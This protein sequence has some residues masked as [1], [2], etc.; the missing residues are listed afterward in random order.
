MRLRPRSLA[1]AAVTLS[2]ALA[3]GACGSDDEPGKAA[4]STGTSASPSAGTSE[5]ASSA[6]ETDAASSSA[7][8][9][10][11]QA[12]PGRAA[13]SAVKPA[14][15][16]RML[17]DAIAEGGTAKLRM[18]MTGQ[19]ASTSTGVAD[20]AAESPAVSLTTS[21]K[22]MGG[23]KS[24]VVMVDGVI[25]MQ[26]G[27]GSGGKYA[28]MDLADLG[29]GADLTQF[30][31][32]AAFKQ[33]AKT[34]SEVT[35]VGEGKVEGEQLHHYRAVVDAG[36]AK[37]AASWRVQDYDAWFDAQGF[38]RKV[39]LDLG[40]GTVSTMTYSDWGR[41]V[42]VA[43]PPADQVVELPSMPQAPPVDR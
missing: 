37:K 9:K 5:G 42:D 19:N 27:T 8:P 15:F 7:S 40:D 1:A 35:Y 2:V 25:Y 12:P 10:N 22:A 4:S 28:K 24:E 30:D 43:K 34:F 33:L 36:K 41:K 32:Q 14:E 6:P 21:V 16:A 31:P 13:G 39:V 20:F 29:A 17:G 23:Q 18:E 38:L 11:E 26:M 3:L